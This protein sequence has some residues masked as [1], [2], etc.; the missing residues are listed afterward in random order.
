MLQA[1]TSRGSKTD[2][3]LTKRFL[4]AQL[5]QGIVF[6]AIVHLL[7]DTAR[8]H[9]TGNVSTWLENYTIEVLPAP[10]QS[11]DLVRLSMFIQRTSGA[12]C[13]ILRKD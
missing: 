6:K 4:V 7:Y 5:Q 12:E 10:A 9:T 3:A 8:A 2:F 11:P 13:A 1:G